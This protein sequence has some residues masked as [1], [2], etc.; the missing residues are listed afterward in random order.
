MKDFSGLP[1]Q[2]YE[3]VKSIINFYEKYDYNMS[4]AAHLNAAL[5]NVLTIQFASG[6]ERTDGLK[7][8]QNFVE[9]SLN[10]YKQFD[11]V[12]KEIFKDYNGLDEATIKMK[13]IANRND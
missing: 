5:F 2:T 4:D 11:E 6:I 10:I 1:L 9:V 12:N 7:E 8:A 3:L 13:K